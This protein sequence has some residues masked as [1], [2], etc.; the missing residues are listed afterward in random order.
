VDDGV[1]TSGSSP[2]KRRA[3]N[4]LRAQAAPSSPQN[5]GA[6]HPAVPF[7]I[8]LAREAD[9]S[10]GRARTEPAPRRRSWAIFV[11]ER[12][13]LDLV[14]IAVFKPEADPPL[15]V[16]CNGIL[17]G[18]IASEGNGGDC[19]AGREGLLLARPRGRPPACVA[20]WGR[21]RRHLASAAGTEE[22]LGRSVGEGLD[23][24]GMQSVT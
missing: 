12:R 8:M 6:Q 1:P 15:V 20:L 3:P 14:R 22:F 17:P 7:G 21:C 19:L 9:L 11:P 5:K 16:H 4:Q 24:T 18:A 13:E 2:S 10:V 23:H